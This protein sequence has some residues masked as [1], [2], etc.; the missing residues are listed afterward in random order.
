VFISKPPD[1]LPDRERELHPSWR[2]YTHKY[3][4]KKRIVR[5]MWIC[6]GALM[7]EAPLAIVLGLALLSALV[8]FAILDE[9]R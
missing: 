3:G 4:N 2:R 1:G 7:L 8:T 6:V 9:T 5:D